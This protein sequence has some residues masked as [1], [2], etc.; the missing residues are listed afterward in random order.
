MQRATPWQA[1]GVG[2]GRRVGSAL[3]VLLPMLLLAGCAPFGAGKGTPEATP[4][5][6]TLAINADDRFS[7]AADAAQPTQADLRWWSRFNDAEMAAWVE[8]ALAG[9][10]DIRIADAQVDQARALL[11]SAQARRG[12]QLGAQAGATLLLQRD[13]GE[14]RVQ[15]GVALQLDFDTD[16]WG[17]LRQAQVS[18]AAGVLRSQDLVQAAR[19]GT[20]GLAARAYLEWRAAQHDA[21]LLVDQLQLQH[22][23][24]RTVTVRVNAGLAPA[25]DRDRV[26]AELAATEAEQVA[27]AVR[28]RQALAALQV[29]AGERP[30]PAPL[31]TGAAAAA[32]AAAQPLPELPALRGGVPVARPLDLLRL[33]PD[34]RAAEQFLLGAA[35]DVGVAEAAL[36]P[37]LRLPGRVVWGAATGAG[38]LDLVSAT[39]AASL[40][41]TLFDGGAGRAQVRA[42][43]A[44]MEQSLA[45]F[46]GVALAALQEVED[47]LVAI[48]GDA[49]RLQR[50]QSAADA[51]ARAELLARQRYTSGLIDFATVL[52]TQRTLLSTQDSVASAQA[53]LS[54]DHVR[55][56]KAL[57][58]GWKPDAEAVAPTTTQP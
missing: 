14:R 3:R 24:V 48:Q 40:D 25:L 15:P 23:L 17:G 43:Q 45:T 18:A 32:A 38:L 21:V 35:A 52:T 55:L 12:M 13:A 9:N 19:L 16:L 58:G 47:A 42:Q 22:A 50:L 8:R 39:L 30:A 1:V 11:Q 7:A 33:R 4:V 31:D 37:S 46:E 20:A 44:A 49:E 2:C 41:V 6:P 29:L 36:R 57:G 51:A 56:Y 53:S 27:A 34:L 5:L 10:P 54:T 28:T 26:M